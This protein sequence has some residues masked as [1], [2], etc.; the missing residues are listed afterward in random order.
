MRIFTQN[1]WNWNSLGKK[2]K[3][4]IT[5]VSLVKTRLGEKV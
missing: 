2:K 5:Y 3:L 1:L 4:V